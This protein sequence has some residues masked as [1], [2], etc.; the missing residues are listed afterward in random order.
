MCF[1][2]FSMAGP[3]GPHGPH[4]DVIV[5]S[6]VHR[7]GQ[8]QG[9]KFNQ[10]R[11]CLKLLSSKAIVMRLCM[12]MGM[13]HRDAWGGTT[14]LSDTKGSL[15]GLL[16]HAFEHALCIVSRSSLSYPRA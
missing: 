3:R 1:A 11:L 16:V 7:L 13:N 9:S 12:C 15:M 10:I 14:V 2:L 4:L 8:G 6:F 5:R